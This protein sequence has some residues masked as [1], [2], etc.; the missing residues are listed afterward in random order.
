MLYSLYR[1]YIVSLKF[2][3]N[4]VWN[5][6]YVATQISVSILRQKARRFVQPARPGENKLT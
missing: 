1:Y 4:E 3:G 5:R 6:D 2:Q